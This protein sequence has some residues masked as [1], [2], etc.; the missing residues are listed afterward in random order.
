M[1]HLIVIFSLFPPISIIIFR[2]PGL[3]LS[4]YPLTRFAPAPIILLKLSLPPFQYS[5]FYLLEFGLIFGSVFPRKTQTLVSNLNGR[6]IFARP[7]HKL[8]LNW[9][10][11]L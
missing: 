9:P 3:L 2:R 8:P 4:I 11:S 10:T 5:S 7:C 1:F 6:A